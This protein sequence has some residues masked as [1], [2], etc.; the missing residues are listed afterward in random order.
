MADIAEL[1]L[2][3]DSKGVV[4]AD[5]NLRKLDKTA[6]G[7]EKRA[8]ALG[9]TIGNVAAAFAGGAF[10]QKVIANT[11]EQERV[12]AQLEQTLKSTGRY[13]PELSQNMQDFAA[14]LQQVTTF[15][16]E[17]I[18]ASQSLLLTFT[19]IGGDVFPR[20]QRAILDVATAMG[21]DLKSASLQV[22]KALNDPILGVTALARSG[23]QFSEAQ[24]AMIK[25]MVETGRVA[26][27]QVVILKELETQ[28]GGSAEAARN[29]LGGALKSLQNTFG[30]LLEGNGDKGGVN[31]AVTSIN[32]LNDT[33]NDP[34]IKKAFQE[35]ASGV[36]SVVSAVAKALPAITGFTK[37]AAEE[38]AV[39][40]GGISGD[41]IVRLEARAD[42]LASM[43]TRMQENGD[44][45]YPVFSTMSKKL[46]E[47]NA[48][49][50]MYYR[51]Q[52]SAPVAPVAATLPDVP[53]LQATG[54]QL[55]EVA[56][57]TKGLTDAQ[58]A[59]AKAAEDLARAQQSNAD[60]IADLA[61][62]IYQATLSADDLIQRQNQ[63]RL[64]EF[65]TPEQIASVK[66]LTAEINKQRV[67]KEAA[68][69]MNRR[70]S[71][72]G[73]DPAATIRGDV[74]PLSGG[75]FDD[76]LARYEAE[77]Q[78]ELIRYQ[79]QQARLAEAINIEL[80]QK[81]DAWLMEE[82]FY[83]EHTAR[84]NQIDQARTDMLMERSA[85]G[86]RQMSSDIMAFAQV[87][88]QENS[89][90]FEIAKAA[91]ITSTIIETYTAAQRAFSAM[92]AIPYVGPA[93][94]VAAAAAAVAGGMARVAQIRSQSP[95]FDGGGFTGY[96][97]RSGGVDGKG[98][99]MAVMHPNETVIDHT[100]GQSTG[101][102]KIVNNFTLNAP[103]DKR[104]QS[105]IAAKIAQAQQRATA[106][107]SA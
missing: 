2:K 7:T 66:M 15:G 45:G 8:A 19:Q 43:L 39:F 97:P 70:R 5:K 95:S 38:L 82:E 78:A 46:D 83:Q 94:G 20:A 88:G 33:L 32:K 29:T 98:G 63:L 3:V 54:G 53:V 26:E 17:A 77:R 14:S 50:E 93:L 30:D 51:L 105:Q 62:Q 100:K 81:Q 9:K 74:A 106:R 107:L 90:M 56:K 44:T 21:T 23:I 87:F 25:E 103:A 65:A 72:F 27:A 99:F 48:K 22:G 91:A 73:S 52:S 35:I 49:I 16:D 102:S 76:Q 10:L 85:A 18:I 41:D 69:E 92:A 80:V 67:A 68:D 12:T 31:A 24:K 75:R 101:G 40:G 36:L 1:G 34:A 79:E 96:G 11:I 64:N 84:L 6:A 61:E 58:K 28:F 104:T 86:F 57:K 55:E 60:V 47:V 71:E 42:R 59:M 37:W 13:T 4:S 89:K